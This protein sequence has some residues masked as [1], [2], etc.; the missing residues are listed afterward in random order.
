MTTLVTFT[1]GIPGQE[2][3]PRLHTD[4]D[5]QV[6]VPLGSNG[7]A[8]AGGGVLNALRAGLVPAA[9]KT[10]GFNTTAAAAVTAIAAVGATYSQ[11]QL[12]AA[13]TAILNAA[14]ALTAA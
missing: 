1:N 13:L 9:T 12:Q 6:S 7:G 14:T 4:S 2:I 3:A 11:A 10:A 8:N 5:G